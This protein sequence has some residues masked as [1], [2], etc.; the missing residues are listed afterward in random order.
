MPIYRSLADYDPS[1]LIDIEFQSHY[2]EIYEL[3]ISITTIFI[4]D[5]FIKIVRNS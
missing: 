1:K 4:C 2:P 5:L 3:F